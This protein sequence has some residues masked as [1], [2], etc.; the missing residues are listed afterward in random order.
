MPADRA[1]AARGRRRPRARATHLSIG[2]DDVRNGGFAVTVAGKRC[3]KG[4]SRESS[5]LAEESAGTRLIVAGNFERIHRQ[6]CDTIG[7]RALRR[8]AVHDPGLDSDPDETGDAPRAGT[9]R[10]SGAPPSRPAGAGAPPLRDPVRPR[11]GPAGDRVTIR[12]EQ[13]PPRRR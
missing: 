8:R 13:R 9:A 6:N 4:P 7:S 1:A 2:A 10:A 3:G 11:R 5:P 12:R